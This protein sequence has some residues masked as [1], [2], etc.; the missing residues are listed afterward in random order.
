MQIKCYHGRCIC[1]VSVNGVM[2]HP[3]FW[4]FFPIYANM[5]AT[6]K[7]QSKPESPCTSTPVFLHKASISLWLSHEW[8][9]RSR[10]KAACH[11]ALLWHADCSFRHARSVPNSRREQYTFV[12]PLLASEIIRPFFDIS[13]KILKAIALSDLTLWCSWISP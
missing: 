2:G 12:G 3:P 7:L 11:S 5:Q 6:E 10:K 9:C 13:A 4:I 8:L 1:P